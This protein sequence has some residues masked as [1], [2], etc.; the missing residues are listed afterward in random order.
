MISKFNNVCKSKSLFKLLTFMCFK[1]TIPFNS[2]SRD[3]QDWINFR[4]N[5]RLI[6]PT[7]QCWLLSRYRDWVLR[8]LEMWSFSWRPPARDGRKT[9]ILIVTSPLRCIWE[10]IARILCRTASEVRGQ[11]WPPMAR[12]AQLR[13]LRTNFDCNFPIE[14]H[15]SVNS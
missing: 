12:V 11:N 6:H 5:G 13:H 1:S 9:P 14:M 3:T 15:L 2:Q 4:Y 8:G 10:L 7:G